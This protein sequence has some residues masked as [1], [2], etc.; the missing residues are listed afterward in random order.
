MRSP[1]SHAGQC[2]SPAAPGPKQELADTAGPWRLIAAGAA[3][4]IALLVWAAWQDA[5]MAVKYTDIDY[6]ASR[7]Q[8]LGQ[9]TAHSATV[10]AAIR[11]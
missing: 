1:R 2:D 3:A 11:S 10:L 7:G 8:Q 5:A 9:I 4:R 6:Q